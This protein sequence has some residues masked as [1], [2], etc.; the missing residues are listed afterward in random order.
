MSISEKLSTV[1]ENVHRVYMAGETIG[2]KYGYEFGYSNGYD[3]GYDAGINEGGGGV[4]LPAIDVPAEPS[5]I[6]L[7]KEAINA[8]GEKFIGTMPEHIDGDTTLTIL[9]PTFKVKDGYHSGCT[10]AVKARAITT[11]KALKDA[12]VIVRDENGAFMATV[13][14][15][16]ATD[17]YNEGLEEGRKT[18]YDRFWDAYQQNGNRTS[19]FCAFAGSCWTPETFKPKYPIKIVETTSS[20]TNAKRMFQ[21]F[22]RG[23]KGTT[24]ATACTLTPDIVDFSECR[25]PADTFA[26]AWFDEVTVDFGNATSLS[27]TFAGGDGGGGISKINIRVTEKAT[28]FSNAFNYASTLKDLIFTDDSVIAASIDV[29]RSPLSK[30][31]FKSIAKALSPNVTA[32]LS[33]QKTAVETEFPDRAEWDALFANKPNWTITEV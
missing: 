23:Q 10:V 28:S 11:A 32:T 13:E 6:R 17:V 9:E 22:A 2:N 15:E 18:E 20:Q 14:I 12:P 21:Y 25:N 1:A 19:Y 3:A 26:N 27:G 24:G 31:S 30:A 4:E 16:P 5:D 33:V 7:G 29:K 8:V